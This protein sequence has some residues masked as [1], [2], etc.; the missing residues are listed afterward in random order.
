MQLLPKGERKTRKLSS[1]NQKGHSHCHRSYH[2]QQQLHSH[3]HTYLDHFATIHHDGLHELRRVSAVCR[4][5]GKEEILESPNLF[6]NHN[7]Q[8]TMG[9]MSFNHAG[10]HGQQIHCTVADKLQNAQCRQWLVAFVEESRS[11]CRT[12]FI[13]LSSHSC[14]TCPLCEHT[15][16]LRWSLSSCKRAVSA[17]NL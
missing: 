5:Q 12:I 17:S 3:K 13:Y 4:L 11:N 15:C 9:N 6:Q 8:H 1:A 7:N 14:E 16:S 10:S 2:P